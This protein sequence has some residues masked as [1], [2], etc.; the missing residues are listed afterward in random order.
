MATAVLE[1]MA[2]R[3]SMLREQ[4]EELQGAQAEELGE[5]ETPEEQE[6]R[7]SIETAPLEELAEMMQRG[8]QDQSES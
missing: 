2:Q 5:G 3:E 8:P 1:G 7:A 6:A 4:E